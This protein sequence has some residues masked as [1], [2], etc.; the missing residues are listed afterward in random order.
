MLDR[1]S[2]LVALALYHLTIAVGIVV[3]PLAMVASRLGITF[4]YH[5]IVD[6]A[7]NRVDTTK[8]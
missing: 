2:K 1:A 6:S 8:Q 3:F 4:P 5:R 7:G